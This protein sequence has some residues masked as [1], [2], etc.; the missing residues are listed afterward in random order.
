ML[1]AVTATDSYTIYNESL[2]GFIAQPAGFVGA[3]WS[4]SAVDYI[5]LTILP[6]PVSRLE[7]R[8]CEL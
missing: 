1:L 8:T 7:S 2:L 6:A 4:G 3:G 5:Q